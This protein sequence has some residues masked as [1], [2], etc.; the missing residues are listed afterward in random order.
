MRKSAIG[1]AAA[2][3]VG[4]L[5]SGLALTQAVRAQTYPPPVGSLSVEAASTTTGSTTSVTA[6]ILD[7]AG[8]PV[9]GAEVTFRITSQPGSDARW[10][11][12]KL[13]ITA[14]TNA[15]GV[16]SAVL[17][18]GNTPGTII[19]ETVSGEKTSQVTV[20]VAAAQLPTTGGDPAESGSDGVPAWQI[21]LLA[22][23][24][25]VLVSGLVVMIRRNKKA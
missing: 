17:S 4:T 3:V 5:I 11:N 8:S 20:A 12:G 23:G 7:N 21:G 13:V 14:I 18:A 22:I 19:V 1:L 15:K 9:E 6:T 25:A 2:L 24:A 10:A 16:A